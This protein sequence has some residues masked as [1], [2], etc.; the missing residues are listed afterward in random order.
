[1]LIVFGFSRDMLAA[2]VTMAIVSFA[3]I[4]VFANSN[5]LMQLIVPD[6]LRGRVLAIYTLM[7]IGT[8]PIGSLLAGVLAK[9]FSAPLTTIMFATVSLLT[10][11]VVCFRPGG[12]RDLKTA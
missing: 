3:F 1:M 4:V 6:S 9:H 7:F 2:Y 10:A 11:L 8:T 5:T 12:L